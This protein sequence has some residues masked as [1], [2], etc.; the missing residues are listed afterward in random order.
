M[1]WIYSFLLLLISIL[2][3][4]SSFAPPS[5]DLLQQSVKQ[6]RRTP[7]TC[8]H[9]APLP[10][11]D[12]AIGDSADPSPTNVVSSTDHLPKSE[13]SAQ[14][15]PRR[16]KQK[17]HKHLFR[18]NEDI[19]VDCWLRCAEPREFLLSCGYTEDE[20]DKMSEEYPQLLSLD[21]HSQLAPK[22]Q[23]IVHTLGG[24]DGDLIWAEEDIF[25]HDEEEEC[26]IKDIN[27][28]HTLR[29]SY[30]AKSSI[31]PE[32]F[33]ARLERHVGPRHAYLQHFGL[34]SGPEL[35][36][37]NGRRLKQFL[38]ACNA[39]PAEFA[40]LAIKWAAESQRVMGGSSVFGAAV[41]SA[42]RVEKFEEAF[43]GGLLAAAK[44]EC[45]DLYA[46]LGSTP[47]Q[48][49]ELLLSHGANHLEPDRHGASPLA[50]AC[51][52][53]NLP[54]VKFLLKLKSQSYRDL[55]CPEAEVVLSTQNPKDGATPLHWAACGIDDNKFGSGGKSKHAEGLNRK[56]LYIVSVIKGRSRSAPL[57]LSHRF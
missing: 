10:T 28:P 9:D 49:V 2:S 4:V 50:W 16:R 36:M 8:R 47:G 18:H 23:F 55:A 52:R 12:I 33:G 41:H 37:A 46:A 30:K 19:S 26:D 27:S 54:A 51:G 31:P 38:G 48:F 6:S 5:L 11:P 43:R 42:S 34:P 3:V 56:R 15:K 13:S 20:I 53:G 22:M 44:R 7:L 1:N 17:P 40:M 14:R 32:F 25:H 24:G 45:E 29:I 35:L 39:P 21:V 57:S